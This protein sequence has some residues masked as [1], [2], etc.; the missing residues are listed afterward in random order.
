MW[1]SLLALGEKEDLDEVV[2]AISKEHSLFSQESDLMLDFL[3]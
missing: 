1:N 2:I 3:C